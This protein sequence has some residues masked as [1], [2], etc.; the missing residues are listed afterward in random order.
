VVIEL[1]VRK[2][3]TGER[4]VAAFESLH[5]VRTW[6]TE[7]PKFMEVLRVQKP[8]DLDEDTERALRAVMRP[9]DDEEVAR[10]DA[11]FAHV[12]AEV[13]AR[14]LLENEA[15]HAAMPPTPEAEPSDIMTI[16]W[17]E[18]QPMRNIGDSRPIPDVVRIAVEAWITERNSWLHPRRQHIGE[19]EL[20]VS[21]AGPTRSHEA[22]RVEPGAN[23][24]TYPGFAET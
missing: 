18:G 11:V 19:A 15:A 13:E 20:R 10:K 3:D 24:I 8:A 22:E 9:L 6:L 4:L 1:L 16:A 5:D 14:N 17:R 21:P 12:T 2:I 7:R 23:F